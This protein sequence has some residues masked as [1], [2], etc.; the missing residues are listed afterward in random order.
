[1]RLSIFCIVLIALLSPSAHAG[2]D[3]SLNTELSELKAKRGTTLSGPLSVEEL[4]RKFGAGERWL[5]I[6]AWMKPDDQ[7]YYVDFRDGIYHDTSYVVVRNGC[8]RRT[9]LM[10]IT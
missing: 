1:M 4:D 5:K 8:V 7:V 9:L 3:C 2:G 6:K 10:S